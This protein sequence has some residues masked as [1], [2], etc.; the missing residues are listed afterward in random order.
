MKHL[1]TFE[2]INL[3]YKKDDYVF[4]IGY[5]NFG[6]FAKISIVNNTNKKRNWDYLIE[7]Y[8]KQKRGFEYGYIDDIDIERKMTEDEILEYEAKISMSKYNL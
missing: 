4:I 2:N 5:P 1:K 6:N 8:N 7:V 3:E